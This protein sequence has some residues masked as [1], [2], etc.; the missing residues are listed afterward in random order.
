M[1]DLISRNDLND[2]LLPLNENIEDLEKELNYNKKVFKED[3]FEG[4]VKK[5]FDE[6]KG[7]GKLSEIDNSKIKK[8]IEKIEV[9]E[10]GKAD[11][12]VNMIN[13]FG[14]NESISIDIR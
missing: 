13:N 5:L 2:F 3:E 11:I 1:D 8:I 14:F 7:I 6:V 10:E 4:E 9:T 12:H